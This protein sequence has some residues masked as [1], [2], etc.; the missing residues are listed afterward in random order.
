M[1]QPTLPPPGKPQPAPAPKPNPPSTAPPIVASWTFAK[2]F[3]E[4]LPVVSFVASLAVFAWATSH[5]QNWGFAFFL[6]LA[7]VA[8]WSIKGSGGRSPQ[9][10]TGTNRSVLWYSWKRLWPNIA[11]G[12]GVAVWVS[13]SSALGL[14]TYLIVKGKP[15][16]DWTWL[17]FGQSIPFISML[18]VFIMILFVLISSWLKKLDFELTPLATRERFKAMLTPYSTATQE[19][20]AFIQGLDPKKWTAKER[21]QFILWLQRNGFQF[22]DTRAAF[23]KHG[24]TELSELIDNHLSANK[25]EAGGVLIVSSILGCT[26]WGLAVVKAHALLNYFTDSTGK[27]DAPK[28]N[29][30]MVGIGTLILAL[31]GVLTYV[32]AY[33]IKSKDR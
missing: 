13:L 32:S 26:I 7:S 24:K 9:N 5:H 2:V 10:P 23:D 15:G 29:L 16:S 33:F 17:L 1:N 12:V 6:L 22:S 14:S 27:L 8:F 20:D 18:Y 21:E 30:V 4:W 28:F 19:F 3:N 11:F 31:I 25:K